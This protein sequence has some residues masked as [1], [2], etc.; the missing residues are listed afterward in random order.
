MIGIIGAMDLEIQA[1][2]EVMNIEN[3]DK[4]LD[5]FFIEGKIGKKDV[6]LVKSGVGKVN[7][8]ITTTLLLE[9]FDIDLIVNIGTAGGLDVNQK[10]LDIVISKNVIQHD[11]DTS[12]LDGPEGLG[13]V[14]KSDEK[15]GKLIEKAFE[16]NKVSSKIHFG[17][18][19]SGDQFIGEEAKTLDL[20]KMFPS[21]IACEMEAG[22]IG[23]TAKKYGIPFIVIRALSDIV[24]HDNSQ[25]DFLKNTKTSS[26][27]SADMLVEFIRN[28][29]IEE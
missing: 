11:F 18:I 12:Y 25:N 29:D 16:N 2:K 3:E 28:L 24:H 14:S 19:I 26:K 13:L 15:L 23:Q 20:I 27:R 4:Y 22:A 7:A 17:D 1:I 6:I 9:K 10:T 21:A 8:A 5:T